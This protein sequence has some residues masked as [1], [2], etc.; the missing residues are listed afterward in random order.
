MSEPGSVTILLRKAKAGDVQA[1][2]EL[3][4][5]MSPFVKARAVAKLKNGPATRKVGDAEDVEASVAGP[6][7]ARSEGLRS[8]DDR[9]RSDLMARLK[10]RAE[11]KAI[12]Y[13]RKADCRIDAKPEA[14]LRRNQDAD[15]NDADAGHPLDA[16]WAAEDDAI[17]MAEL[18]DGLPVLHARVAELLIERCSVHEIAQKLG[19][20]PYRVR[21]T[22]KELQ[23]V[24][25]DRIMPP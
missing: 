3:R 19:L 17:A 7:F 2:A 4:K 23:R 25:S 10:H 24:L 12:D 8:I 6:V 18:L 16:V 21:K 22:V 13:I 14:D 11:N 15:A 20:T 1:R 5:K 9:N